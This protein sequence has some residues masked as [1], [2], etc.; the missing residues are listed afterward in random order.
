MSSAVQ[1]DDFCLHVGEPCPTRLSLSGEFC[2]APPPPASPC[3]LA[4]C[5]NGALCMETAGTAACQCAPGFE[6][7]RCEKLVSVNFVDGDS[8]VQLQDVRNWPQANITLQVRSAPCGQHPRAR[9]LTGV[10]CSQ[11]STA[12]DNGVLLY[13]GD[14][15]PIAVELHQGHVRVTYDPGNQPATAIYRCTHTHTRGQMVSAALW[16]WREAGGRVN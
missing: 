3:Q 7:Q 2:E 14:N 8:Y 9:A 12:E 1:D 13:N 16:R 6:G 10:V 11:V 5:Q 4:Q 15:E